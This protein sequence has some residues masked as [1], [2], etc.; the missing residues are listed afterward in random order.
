M[1]LLRNNTESELIAQM[2]KIMTNR[3]YLEANLAFAK[4]SRIKDRRVKSGVLL[5]C[6]DIV[7]DGVRV[8]I[9]AYKYSYY[10][11]GV[12]KGE[13][14]TCDWLEVTDPND[15]AKGWLQPCV[16][17]DGETYDSAMLFSPHFCQRVKERSGKS[18][19]DHIKDGSYKGQLFFGA[20]GAFNGNPLYAPFGEYGQAIVNETA[21]GLIKKPLGFVRVLATYVSTS[22]LKDS[23]I[24]PVLAQGI[25]SRERLRTYNDTKFLYF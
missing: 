14:M 17:P 15:G 12:Y 6:K 21:C 5:G 23:Q 13:A 11:G 18:F 1:I 24:L 20:N 4:M 25:D 10:K 8:F 2:L 19:I 22:M 9:S 7:V 16:A 3:K